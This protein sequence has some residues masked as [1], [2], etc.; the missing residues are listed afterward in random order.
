M[1][2]SGRK[3]C[4]VACDTAAGVRHCELDLPSSAS[5]AEALAAARAV[6]G[7]AACDWEQGATGVY[8]ELKP[9][10]YVPDDGDR[11]ELY[12]ALL[13]DPRAQRRARAKQGTRRR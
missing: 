7:D 11:I 9:R 6:L 1:S 3:R 10:T 4:S 5:I 12:R 13:L 8:G 2:A